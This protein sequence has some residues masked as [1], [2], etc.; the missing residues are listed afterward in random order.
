MLWLSRWLQSC[1]GDVRVSDVASYVDLESCNRDEACVCSE[2]RVCGAEK[3]E[4]RVLSETR[5][6][7]LM[8]SKDSLC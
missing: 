3:T 5:P 1:R 8:P 6:L 2:V 4:S 7:E